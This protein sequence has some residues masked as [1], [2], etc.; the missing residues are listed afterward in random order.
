[1]LLD[2]GADINERDAN[3]ITPLIIAIT[4]NHPDVARFLIER[5]ADIN[6][7]DWYG[8]T[9]LWAAVETRNMDVDNG[10]FD[11]SIDRAP[12]L[13]L[14][15]VL[16]DRGADPNARTKEVPPIRRR[17]LRITGIAG[18]GGLHRPD[19]VPRPRRSPA[20]STV[21][22]LLLKHGA[23]PNIPT[24]GGTTALMAA[25]GVNWVVDQTF[26]EGPTGAA[27]GR[28]AVRRARAWTST[29]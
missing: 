6:A 1:M 11:N 22:K 14:I 24:F 20:T 27:R 4:N 2:A 18:V 28:E 10:T 15:Q 12:L 16:L 13:E 21:M 8:R 19:A 3:G 23:D 29:R 9:P 5:G 17:F 26:D 25:A 7:V